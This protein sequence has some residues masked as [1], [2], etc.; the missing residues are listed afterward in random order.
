MKRLCA[1]SLLLLLL[2]SC[3]SG[4]R[5]NDDYYVIRYVDIQRVYAYAA[6][7][8]EVVS[9]KSGDTTQ[10]DAVKNRIYGRIKTAIS[11]VARRHNADFILNTGDAV[12]YSR[13]S[14]DVTDDV[15][16]EYK[17]INDITSPDAK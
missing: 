10:G 15:I 11:N 4:L 3:S 2:V 14:Y 1:V 9:A 17:K 6:K 8:E 12:L 13:T 7:Y 5:R 16:R